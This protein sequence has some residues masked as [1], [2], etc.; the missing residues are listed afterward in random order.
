[1]AGDVVDQFTDA[2]ASVEEQAKR[3]RRLIHGP[4]EFRDVRK[5]QGKA[6]P[7]GRKGK[8]VK[9]KRTW[10]GRG[11][12]NVSESFGRVRKSTFGWPAS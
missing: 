3:K 6:A 5:D 11:F 1:M 7:A 8:P 4:R 2:T 10:R 12:K 9:R